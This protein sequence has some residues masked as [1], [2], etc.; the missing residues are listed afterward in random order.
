MAKK[1][2]IVSETPRSN[3][4]SFFGSGTLPSPLIDGVDVFFNSSSPYVLSAEATSTNLPLVTFVDPWGYPATPCHYIDFSLIPNLTDFQCYNCRLGFNVSLANVVQNYPRDYTK[5]LI[6]FVDP[7]GGP[8]ASTGLSGLTALTNVNIGGSYSRIITRTDFTSCSSLY[9]LNVENNNLQNYNLKLKN[10]YK[11]NNISI[12]GN[13]LTSTDFLMDIASSLHPAALSGSLTNLYN[14]DS[15]APNDT[16]KISLSNS[17]RL[18]TL[19]AFSGLQVFTIEYGNLTDVNLPPNIALKP[20][21]FLSF[22]RNSK[23]SAFKSGVNGKVEQLYLVGCPLSGRNT[24]FTGLSGLKRITAPNTRFQHFTDLR[25][26][27]ALSALR[28][29]SLG[30]DGTLKDVDLSVLNYPANNSVVELYLNY[31]N[32]LTSINFGAFTFSDYPT[33]YYA[34]AMGTL[35]ITNC[36]NLSTLNMS[37]LSGLSRLIAP[38]TAELRSINL[39]RNSGL[40]ELE[41]TYTRLTDL[42]LTSPLQINL[43]KLTL[44]YNSY[45]SNLVTNGLPSLQY[46]NLNTTAASGPTTFTNLSALKYLYISNSSITNLD[47]SSLSAL[48]MLDLGNNLSLANL[49]TQPAFPALTAVIIGTLPSLPETNFSNFLNLQTFANTSNYSSSLQLNNNPNL[50]SINI[51]DGYDY[52]NSPLADLNITN[53]PQLRDFTY[54]TDA[55]F[56]SDYSNLTSLAFANCD[57]LS[58]TSIVAANLSSIEF[59][60]ELPNLKSLS[61]DTLPIDDV[62][63]IDNINNLQELNLVGLPNLK[64]LNF[65]NASNLQALRMLYL[66]ISS[67]DSAFANANYSLSSLNIDFCSNLSTI[68]I[69]ISATAVNSTDIGLLNNKFY[70]KTLDQ[71]LIQLDKNPCNFTNSKVLYLGGNA[72]SRSKYTD[73]TVS[74]LQSKGWILVPSTSI[75]ASPDLFITPLPSSLPF[76][77][78]CFVFTSATYLSAFIDTT[79]YVLSGPGSLRNY[80][81]S[82]LSGQGTIT[83]A[84]S[85]PKTS[86]FQTNSAIYHIPVVKKDISNKMALSGLNKIYTGNTVAAS[87]NVYGYPQIST[88]LIYL[89]NGVSV[90]PVNAGYYTVSSYIVDGYYTG[91]FTNTLSVLDANAFYSIPASATSS[92][93]YFPQICDTNKDIVVTF[94]YAFYGNFKDG[95]EGFCINFT[96]MTGDGLYIYRPESTNNT[97]IS[98]GGPGKALNYANLTLLSATGDTFTK[99]NYTGKFK[100]SLGVGFD[101]S[102]NFAL[103]SEGVNGYSEAIN[104]S[105]AVRDSEVNKFTILTR[106]NNLTAANNKPITVFQSTTGSP[107]YKSVRARLTNF[108]KKLT[109]DMKPLTAEKYVNY[110]TYDLPVALPEALSVAISYSSGKNSP[111]F[112]IKNANLNCF[113][114]TL[115]AGRPY[116]PDAIS[117]INRSGATDI[118]AINDFVLQT[119]GLGIWDKLICW[120]MRSTLNAGT[121]RTVYGLGGLT[122]NDGKFVSYYDPDMSVYNPYNYLSFNA[123]LTGYDGSNK[124]YNTGTA[125]NYILFDL[126]NSV[127]ASYNRVY[128]YNGGIRFNPN[129]SISNY[130]AYAI[131]NISMYS[132]FNGTANYFT[133]NMWCKFNQLAPQGIYQELSILNVGR[134]TVNGFRFY[135]EGPTSPSPVPYS[136]TFATGE[137]GGTLGIYT[138]YVPPVDT[139]VLLSIASIN[140]TVILY[141]DGVEIGRGSGTW[142]VPE[143]G[144]EGKLVINNIG[145]QGKTDLTVYSLEING[146]GFERKEIQKYY[147]QTAPTYNK[148]LINIPYPEW[149]TD[150]LLFTSG[151]WVEYNTYSNLPI[152][153]K[154]FGIASFGVYNLNCAECNGYISGPNWPCNLENEVKLVCTMDEQKY[155]DKLPKGLSV[156]HPGGGCTQ[157]ASIASINYNDITLGNAFSGNYIRV[158]PNSLDWQKW[159]EFIFTAWD[160]RQGPE[161]YSPPPPLN[162]AYTVTGP[163]LI[164]N[165]SYSE[166]GIIV[167][168]DYGQTPPPYSLPLTTGIGHRYTNTNNTVSLAGYLSESLSDSQWQQL[169]N[170][171]KTT[172]CKD[173]IT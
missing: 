87:A 135:L 147:N 58:A 1:I 34:Q 50:I 78:T 115:S 141:A 123:S 165:T 36:T 137:Q 67:L 69:P 72:T 44:L 118:N 33:I 60:N 75:L 129:Y 164:Q 105:I 56:N 16:Y 97:P 89:Q 93:V 19:T 15:N 116:D 6:N 119:K 111:V 132:I 29:V 150:G 83:L 163:R 152:G 136:L 22:S 84:L 99:V 125:G 79:C 68:N 5:K 80:T 121:G 13:P 4:A 148:P 106:T 59:V 100:G 49:Q 114:S 52:F 133:I 143:P 18:N 10:S 37:G 173:Q 151:T 76:T 101:A 120:P 30:G 9:S 155:G 117:Y 32:G 63:A 28:W 92:A 169:Y 168:D 171:L 153:F 54:D 91:T 25:G 55:Y 46:F 113:F 53:N 73:G 27:S 160:P 88:Q 134:Y 109:V 74:S 104:N 124:W 128:E 35:D 66:P 47:V 158:F 131:T 45:L 112:K 98:G 149:T 11:L 172:L 161:T 23:L 21:N 95:Y 42:N 12:G 77:E 31:S 110:L 167:Q 20:D 14:I 64:T 48:N 24:D 65:S 156:G 102:G 127:G 154:Q 70:Y 122:A 40:K 57:L 146:A 43:Q 90:T 157:S 41:L 170:L 81:L 86:V 96:D 17:N 7:G 103:S 166:V 85:T 107:E 61:L 62:A 51:V 138:S 39:P 108:G 2:F 142:Y 8:M 126:Y 82:A 94:D 140:N 71:F 159:N 162:L 3:A 26:L 38:Y 145:G 130:G 144:S 139:P